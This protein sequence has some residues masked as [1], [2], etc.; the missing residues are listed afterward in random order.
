MQSV[1]VLNTL[2][3]MHRIRHVPQ[4]LPQSVRL[5]VAENAPLPGDTHNTCFEWLQYHNNHFHIRSL[6][7]KGPLLSIIPQ[8]S[9]LTTLPALINPNIYKSN[10]R[11]E[12]K[13]IQSQG[14]EEEWQANNFLLYN[15]PGLRKSLK[16]VNQL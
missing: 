9:E 14:N 13:N 11:R 8:I 16:K 7:Y 6:F 4:A 15:I 10:V 2:I 5:T 3:F 12:L 1:I